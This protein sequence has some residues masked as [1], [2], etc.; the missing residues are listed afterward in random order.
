MTNQT[1]PF[2][3]LMP[4]VANRESVVDTERKLNEEKVKNSINMQKEFQNFC[5]QSMKLSRL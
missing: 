4:G 5:W 3:V 2:S 1:P